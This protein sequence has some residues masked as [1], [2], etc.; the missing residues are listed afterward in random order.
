MNAE[1]SLL[2]PFPIDPM[3]LDMVEASLDYSQTID[4]SGEVVPADPD[5]VSLSDI[6][7]FLSG[8]S[9]DPLGQIERLGVTQTIFGPLETTSDERPT[10]RAY[11]VIRSL[12]AEVRRLRGSA[13]AGGDS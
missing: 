11:D 3:T 13:G 8:T 4:E 10:Y 6:C 5:V 1:E 7:D 12:I 9:T 2:P